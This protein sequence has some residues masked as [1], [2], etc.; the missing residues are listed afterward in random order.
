[1]GEVCT[2]ENIS[3]YISNTKVKNYYTEYF[4]SKTSGGIFSKHLIESAS[5][6]SQISSDLK[7]ASLSMVWLF[8]REHTR[9]RLANWAD[10][11]AYINQELGIPTVNMTNIPSGFVRGEL[12]VGSSL[13]SVMRLFY[14]GKAEKNQKQHIL[15]NRIVNMVQDYLRKGDVDNL[16]SPQILKGLQETCEEKLTK[17]SLKANLKTVDGLIEA[18]RGFFERNPT[19]VAMA[20]RTLGKYVLKNRF[21]VKSYLNLLKKTQLI[22]SSFILEGENFKSVKIVN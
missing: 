19:K 13:A 21:T 7:Q 20:F 2:Q 6:K 11:V 8:E 18:G 16:C 9:N 10:G 17:E 1:M 3:D 12:S 5:F 22:N 15:E 14:Y 4:L